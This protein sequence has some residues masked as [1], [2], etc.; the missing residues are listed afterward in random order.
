ML[1][2][3]IVWVYLSEL[4]LVS[5][6]LLFKRAKTKVFFNHK[7]MEGFLHKQTT[8]HITWHR[9]ISWFFVVTRS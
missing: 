5:C 1:S 6:R 9:H 4:A 2:F 3:S 8:S 7:A